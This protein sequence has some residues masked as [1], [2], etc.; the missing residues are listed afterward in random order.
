MAASNTTT[1][2]V[3][4]LERKAHLLSLP[5]ELFWM[6]YDYTEARESFHLRIASVHTILRRPGRRKQIAAVLSRTCRDL[7]N[8]MVD[9]LYNQHFHLSLANNQSIKEIENEKPVLAFPLKARYVHFAVYI[10][11][12]ASCWRHIEALGRAVVRLQTSGELREFE[13]EVTITGY[14]W[15]VQVGVEVENWLGELR[16]EAVMKGLDKKETELEF[17]RLFVASLK[18]KLDSFELL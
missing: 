1:T 3:V 16:T 13:F 18:A 14:R 8:R 17:A 11:F 9:T 7:R 4:I 2:T 5:A 12:R 10:D 6:I 15:G